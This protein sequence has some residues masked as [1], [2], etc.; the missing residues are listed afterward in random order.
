MPTLAAIVVHGQTTV[1]SGYQYQFTPKH[2]GADAEA[3][4]WLPRL[5]LDEEFAVFNAA[6]EHQLM[7]DSGSLYGLQRE[8]HDGLRTI[9]TRSEQIAEFPHAREGEP[10]HGYPH[11]PL[12]ELGHVERRGKRFPPPKEVFQ[13][14]VETGLI[15]NAMK[16]RLMGGKHV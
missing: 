15:S 10:W 16:R 14:M 9:G 8:G 11:Y 5:T 12:K 2:H 7:D 13:R 3:A 1:T 4:Q 6:D